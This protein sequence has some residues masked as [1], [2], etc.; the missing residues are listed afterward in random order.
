MSTK[1]RI[2]SAVAVFAVAAGILTAAE[3]NKPKKVAVLDKPV[4]QQAN[5]PEQNPPP[6]PAPHA[7]KYLPVHSFGGY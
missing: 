6:K 2:F 5:P 1:R 7:K 4:A 3:A